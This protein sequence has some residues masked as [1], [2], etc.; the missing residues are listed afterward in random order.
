MTIK[1]TDNAINQIKEVVASQKMSLEETN[2]RVG[3]RGQSCSG[4]VY[5]FGL[6]DQFNPEL[7]DLIVQDGVRIVHGK[8]FA[9]ELDKITIDFKETEGARGFTFINPLQILGEGGCCGGSCGSGGC[10]E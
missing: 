4:P 2:V 7:D 10:S 8:N 6:D 5:A 1:I 3:I 9:T